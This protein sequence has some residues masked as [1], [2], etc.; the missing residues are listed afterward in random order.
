MLA[1]FKYTIYNKTKWINKLNEFKDNK[2][3]VNWIDNA[4]LKDDSYKHARIIRDAYLRV[5][6]VTNYNQLQINNYLLLSKTASIIKLPESY[7]QYMKDVGGK[8]RNMIRK[9]EKN[10]IEC[11]KIIWNDYLYDIYEIN[12][13]TKER[14][15]KIMKPHYNKLEKREEIYCN[16]YHFIDTIGCIKDNKLIGYLYLRCHNDCAIISRFLGHF[17]HK[18]LGIMNKLVA[19]TV[20]LLIN[21]ERYKHVKSIIYLVWDDTGLTGFK[22]RCGFKPYLLYLK[23]IQNYESFIK[24][25]YGINNFEKLNFTDLNYNRTQKLKKIENIKINI[26]KPQKSYIP[27]DFINK[28][29]EF[30]KDDIIIDIGSSNGFSTFML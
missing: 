21:D 30:D 13:S 5:M 8:T 25:N 9:A 16:E 26:V 12:T 28:H 6:Q 20:N 3:L 27:I 4:N 10:G 1:E 2:L 7:E 29:I 22:K 11:K 14:Q 15:G 23:N 19:G 18:S 17:E 24:I